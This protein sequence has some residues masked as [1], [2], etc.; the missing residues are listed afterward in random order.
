[1]KDYDPNYKDVKHY[2]IVGQKAVIFNS[3]NKILL[4]KRSDKSGG[5]GMWSFPGGGLDTGEKAEVGMLREIEEETEITV[6][7]LRPFYVKTY[8]NGN[9]FTVI[10]AYRGKLHGGEVILNW[11][12]DEFKWLSKEDALKLN[13][14]EDAEDI[15]KHFIQYQ[16]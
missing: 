12:H 1:M 6:N 8:M 9:D 5:G 16:T 13:L 7:D 11:E 14:T 3:K 4:L 10:I 2:A 15:L